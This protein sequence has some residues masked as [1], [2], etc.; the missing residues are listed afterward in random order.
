MKVLSSSVM[1]KVEQR[2]FEIYGED[3]AELY[4]DAA[5]AGIARGIQG[6][7]VRKKDRSGKILLLCGP[8]NNG[9]DALVC[10]CYLV[11]SGDHV[12]AICDMSTLSHR[13]TLWQKKYREFLQAGGNVLNAEEVTEE[14]ISDCDLVVD[15]LFGTGFRGQISGLYLRLIAMVNRKAPGVVSVDIPSGVNGDLGLAEADPVQVVR[16]DLTFFLGAPK[17]GAFFDR[18]LEWTGRFSVLSFGLP[19]ELMEQASASAR[20]IEPESSELRLPPLRRCQHKYEAGF[21]CGLTGSRGMDGA[22]VLSG[23]AALTA[24]A[25]IVRILS[26]HP[27]SRWGS[28]C[29]PELLL[30]PAGSEDTEESVLSLDHWTPFLQKAAAVYLGPGIGRTPLAEKSCQWVVE[31]SEAPLVIDADALFFFAS[32]KIRLSPGRQAILTPHLGELASLLR[33]PVQKGMNPAL[34]EQCAAWVQEH[35]V[36]LLVK[37]APV[38][39]FYP[40]LPDCPDILSCGC[41]GMATAGSGD[42]LTGIVASLLAQGLSPEEAVRT[43]AFLHGRAGER[44][45]EHLGD[46]SLTASALIH[47]LPGAIMEAASDR[48]ML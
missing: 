37:G 38:F 33:Q 39:I 41:P 3:Q 10:G 11:R 17:I 35:S 46:R 27:P 28:S 40:E 5:G 16:S 25:G 19:D 12:S 8:G 15:G 31:H 21:V 1:A 2:A 9:A 42:V 43:G 34:K 30:T 14:I 13:G 22:A 32:G 6:L 47:N 45:R 44:A 29:P 24:G 4:M 48:L 26:L 7:S 23:M 18:C 36:I 20:L